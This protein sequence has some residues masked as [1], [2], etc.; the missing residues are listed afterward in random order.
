MSLPGID[1]DLWHAQPA[2]I[3]GM[4]AT[5]IANSFL[6]LSITNTPRV[7]RMNTY[8]ENITRDITRYAILCAIRN[9]K[10]QRHSDVKDAY[11]SLINCRI[12]YYFLSSNTAMNHDMN[13]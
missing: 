11:D 8:M 2:F 6:R 7:F 1:F 5:T 13:N 9:T 12:N 4:T 10:V 3:S